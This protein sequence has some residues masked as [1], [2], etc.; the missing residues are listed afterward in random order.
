MCCVDFKGSGAILP[1]FPFSQGCIKLTIPPPG[2]RGIISS[3]WGKKIKWERSEK[4]REREKEKGRREREGK[5]GKRKGKKGKGKGK[6]REGSREMGRERL[7]FF[8]REMGRERLDF[9]P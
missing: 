6:G 4:G 7:D 1:P 9:L 5:K 2:G 3:W 8:P